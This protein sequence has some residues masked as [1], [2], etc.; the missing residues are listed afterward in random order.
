MTSTTRLGVRRENVFIS[1]S[2][3]DRED[4]SV[5]NGEPW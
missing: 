5:G 3:V 4:W 1:L 2:F